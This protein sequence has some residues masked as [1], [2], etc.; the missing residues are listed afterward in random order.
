[1]A[2]QQFQFVWIMVG[3]AVVGIVAFLILLVARSSMRAPDDAGEGARSIYVPRWYEFVLGFIVL[4]VVALVLVWQIPPDIPPPEPEPA[5]VAEG[6]AEPAATTT[7]EAAATEAAPEATLEA[8]SEAEAGPEDWRLGARANAFFTVMLIIGA[9]ALLAFVILVFSRVLRTA[10]GGQAAPSAPT[11]TE[12]PDSSGQPASSPLRLLG[13]IGFIAIVLILNWT[14]VDR[15]TQQDMMLSLFYPATLAVALVL[16]FDKASRSW[17][18]KGSAESVREW[19]FCDAIVFFLVLG[20]LNLR[21]FAPGEEQTYG[22][23]FWDMLHIAAFFVTYWIIDRTAARL[24]FLFAYAYIALLTILLV[25]WRAVLGVTVPET[26]DWWFGIWPCFVLVLIFF[27]FEIIL[28]IASR[29]TPRH[30]VGAVK[31]AI[32]FIL[33]AIL[34]ILTIPEAVA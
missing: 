31:D 4:V 9:L 10:P 8:E 20:Y 24:R 7:E 2:D 18:L 29:D 12:P 27:V 23:L 15:A 21:G 34:L 19:L 17:S 30:S 5:A 16:L 11:Q 26:L 1:M 14:A 6:E 3:I 28:L 32:F 25:V 22:A 13:L 33:Y